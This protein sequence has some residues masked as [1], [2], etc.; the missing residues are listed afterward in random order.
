MNSYNKS[1]TSKKQLQNHPLSRRDFLSTSLKASAAAFTTSLIPNLNASADERYNVLFIMVDDLRPLLGC[2]GHTEIYTPNIDRLASRGTVF[3]RAYCQFPVCNPSRASILTGLRPETTKVLDNYSHYRDTVPDVISLPQYFKKH[4]Y[5]TR[6]IGKIMHGPFDDEV[7]WSVPSWEV[8]G[9]KYKNIPSW[10]SLDVQDDDLEDGKIAKHTLKVL[11]EVQNSEFFLAVGFNKPHLPFDAPKQYYSLYESLDIQSIPRIAPHSKHELRGYSD[12]PQGEEA[13]SDRKTIELIKGYM[14][15]I[16][17]M[18]AQVGRILDELDQIG[19]KDKTIILL[20]GDHGFHLGEHDTI[21][22]R[23]LF[24]VALRS[25]LIINIPNQV[26]MNVKTNGIVELIDIYPTLCDACELPIPSFLEGYSMLQLINKPTLSWKT[27]AFSKI[28]TVY[29]KKSI[30]TDR[31]RYTEKV[32]FGMI[33]NE[34]YDHYKDPDELKNIAQFPE[35]ALL[36][37]ELHEKLN[38]GWQS[39]LPEVSSSILPWDFNNDGIVDINDL[40]LISD[41]FGIESSN[42]SL[43]DLNKDG[44]VDLIDLLIVAAHLGETKTGSSPQQFLL[45]NG[46]FKEIEDWIHDAQN[47]N[48]HSSIIKKGI[49]NLESLIKNSVEKN[50]LH[51]SNYPNPFNPE[52]WIPYDLEEDADVSI[53]IHN[54]KGHIVRHLDIGFQSKGVYRDKSNAGYWN[55]KNS[56]GE[57]VASGTYFYT[58]NIKYR[59]SNSIKTKFRFTRKMELIK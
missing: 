44:K 42:R 40:F 34:L 43:F 53:D 58:F 49:A 55:G 15:S 17:Y 27:A 14:A 51:L 47:I 12:I 59:N 21:G 45:Q 20:C 13:L 37:D 8:Q 56:N 28:G 2:Y 3:N 25:P 29:G 4:G 10:Q 18:D 57:K 11:D 39:A 23:T 5:H 22:K 16:S 38:A 35:N 26:H 19:L 7:S 46:N 52:T 31:Y 1:S 50:S 24:E 6:S 32:R 48:S 30:R 9:G 41:N 54:I 33:G 36:V